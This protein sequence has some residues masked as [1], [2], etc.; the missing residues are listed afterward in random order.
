MKVREECDGEAEK[1]GDMR[2]RIVTLGRGDGE[3]GPGEAVLLGKN[4]GT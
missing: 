1:N 2:W 3:V 4:K